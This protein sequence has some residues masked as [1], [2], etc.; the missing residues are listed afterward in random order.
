MIIKR[1]L[2]VCKGN[3]DRSPMMAAV[4]QMYLDNT[5]SLKGEVQCESAGMLE[6]AD[7]GGGASPLMIKAARR[8]G[9]DLSSH[10]KRWVNSLEIGN[11]DLFVC[12]DEEVA[13]HVIELGADMKKVCNAGISNP[14]PSQFQRDFDDTSERIMGAMFRVITR[15]FSE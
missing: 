6:I 2:C 11:Y 13:A 10:N 1:V 14:W 3:S 8:I 12:V 15:Y 7:K 4:L 9:L 5:I